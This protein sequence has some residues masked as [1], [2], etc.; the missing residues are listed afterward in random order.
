MYPHIHIGIN[1]P[2]Y[3][4]MT[5]IGFL[6]ASFLGIRR[7]EYYGYNDHILLVM[8]GFTLV[9]MGLGSKVL[10]FLTQI[11]KIAEDFTLKA[12][13]E[14]FGTSG[15]VFYGGLLGAMTFSY[16]GAKVIAVNPATM[17]SFLTPSFVVFHAF[18]RIGCFLGGCCYGIPWKYG[19]A[20]AETPEIK[21]V[22]VQLIES[23]FEF[24]ILW[25]LLHI[26]KKGYYNL[27]LIY[28]FL[29]AI[30][31]FLDEFL[32]GDSVRG[33]WYMG[34]STSQYISI[35]IFIIV[36]WYSWQHRTNS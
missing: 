33:I 9:G 32:R 26:E 13:I 16:L 11:P 28:L 36:I 24:F 8:I 25:V 18:G 3:S 22:P 4:L 7:K 35:A 20:M 21:R 31:R 10:F 34:L 17:L 15:F 2:T 19:V 29:Y 30:V 12:I 5:G 6:F 23:G 1:I 14:T 27:I